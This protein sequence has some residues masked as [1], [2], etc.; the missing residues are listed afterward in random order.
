[1]SRRKQTTLKLLRRARTRQSN[2]SLARVSQVSVRRLLRECVAEALEPRRLLTGAPYWLTGAPPLWQEQGPTWETDAQT[3]GL[4]KQHN[5]VAGAVNAIAFDPK[6]P[7]TL[8]AATV[9]GG[10]WF[11]PVASASS[12]ADP[13]IP[14]PTWVP[15]TDAWQSDSFGAIAFDP[16]DATGQTIWAGMGDFSSGGGDGSPASGLLLTTDK[17][18]TWTQLGQAAL[19]G[20]SI[21]RIVPTSVVTENPDKTLTTHQVLVLA[22]T[23]GLFFSSDR[24]QTFFNESG[25]T[26]KDG[27]DNDGDGKIDNPEEDTGLPA[28]A[29]TDVVRDSYGEL[30][31]AIPGQGIF[32]NADGLGRTWKPA[33][34]GL[35]TLG[36]AGNRIELAVSPV[37]GNS[38]SGF[39]VMYAVITGPNPPAFG[40]TNL[41]VFRSPDFGGHWTLMGPTPDTHPAGQGNLHVAIVADPTNPYVVWVSGDGGD[42]QTVRGDASN[43]DNP[44]TSV[45]AGS[46]NN[47]GPHPDSRDM[48]FDKAGNL[49][50]ADDG[51]IYR[52]LKPND[53]DNRRWEPVVGNMN[54]HEVYSVAHVSR[55][56]GGG[57][58]Y[59][60]GTQD[61]GTP[62]EPADPTYGLFGGSYKDVT[63][64]DGSIVAVD[65][66]SDPNKTF[67]FTSNNNLIGFQMQTFEL[68]VDHGQNVAPVPVALN[69]NNSGMALNSANFDPTIPS[70]T[71]YVLNAVNAKQMLFGTGYLYESFDQGQNLTLLN[72]P[73]QN[74]RPNPMT[75]V[76]QVTALAY[77]GTSGGVA[78]ASVIY[79]AVGGKIPTLY[80]RTSGGG[81][82]LRVPYPSAAAG[83][84]AVGGARDIVLDPTEY[85]TAWIADANGHIYQTS[86]A[87]QT[88]SDVTGDLYKLSTDLR[89][90]EVFKSGATIV[91]MVGG[92]GGVFKCLNPG[93]I[94]H[95]R[96]CGDGLPGVMVKD[97]HYDPIKDILY[98]GTWGRGIWAMQAGYIAGV[99][100]DLKPYLLQEKDILTVTGADPDGLFNSESFEVYTD[101]ANPRLLT[102][103]Y[104]PQL[105]AQTY[106]LQA[107]CI[108]G[109][110]IKTLSG[111]DNVKID[112]VPAY[113]PVTVDTGAADAF[114]SVAA[115]QTIFGTYLDTRGVHANLTITG[116][117]GAAGHKTELA[118]GAAAFAGANLMQVSTGAGTGSITPA[119]FGSILYDAGAAISSVRLETQLATATPQV[120]I[121]ATGV[122][123]TIE[124]KTQAPAGTRINAEFDIGSNNS[125]A[126]ITAALSLY[127]DFNPDAFVIFLD[128]TDMAKRPII[129]DE[130]ADPDAGVPL[131]RFTGLAPAT[132]EI[133][134]QITSIAA[135]TGIDPEAIYFKG[136][137]K[138]SISVST[139]PLVTL[140]NFFD[141]S[142]GVVARDAPNFQM[143][144]NQGVGDVSL[145]NLSA[146]NL[147]KN[148]IKSLSLDEGAAGA[149]VT[150]NMISGDV[151]L[152][153]LAGTTD[154]TSF[155]S[156]I[157]KG[158]LTLRGGADN[159]VES[160]T[161]SNLTL[162]GATQRPVVL[163]NTIVNT[164]QISGAGA[165][166][167]DIEK[168]RIGNIDVKV[169]AGGTIKGNNVGGVPQPPV[170]ARAPQLDPPHPAPAI[171][172]Q[173]IATSLSDGFVGPLPVPSSQASNFVGPLQQPALLAT[174]WHSDLPT[175]LGA[176]PTSEFNGQT[177]GL[178]VQHNPVAGAVNA[179]APDPGNADIL[180]VA[181]VNGGIWKTTNAR[182]VT[183]DVLEPD[184]T[185]LTERYQSLSFGAIAF[186]PTDKTNQTL[187]AGFDRTSSGSFDGGGEPGLLRTSDGGKTWVPM[188]TAPFGAA[189]GLSGTGVRNIVP[190]TIIDPTSKK[191]VILA[192]TNAGVF[193]SVDGGTIFTRVSGASGPAASGLTAGNYTS[194]VADPANP[195]RFYA[196]MTSEDANA[197]NKLDPGED[198][199]GDKKLE[200][201]HLYRSDDG[202]ATWKDVSSNVPVPGVL[203]SAD[204]IRLAVHFNAATGSNAVW[205]A[206][207][208]LNT[209]AKPPLDQLA[210]VFRSMSQ[211]SSWSPISK[212]AQINPEGQA[213]N[214]SIAADPVNPN[215]V[216][217][218]G[219]EQKGDGI[220]HVA[221]IWRGDASTDNFSS[222]VLDGANGTAPH[223]DSR[224]MAFDADGNLINSNDGGVYRLINPSQSSR[225][226]V[227]AIGNL[228]VHEL[229]SAAYVHGFPKSGLGFVAGAQDTGVPEQ[230]LLHGQGDTY[231]ARDV[232]ES[233]GALV[234]VDQNSTPGHSY[235]YSSND[236]LARFT[237]QEFDSDGNLVQQNTPPLNVNGTGGVNLSSTFDP[238]VRFITPWVMNSVDGKRL[239]FGTNYLYE[240]LDRGASLTMLNGPLL[241]NLPDPA[242]GYGPISALAYGG[243]SGGID[244]PDVLYAASG[245]L[246]F[247]KNAD[248]TPVNPLKLLVRDDGTGAPALDTYPPGT[249]AA[250]VQGARAI[251][252][253]P[254]EWKTVYLL[255][256]NGHIYRSTDAGNTAAGWTDITGDLGNLS[257]DLRCLEL[258]KT[259]GHTV[260]LAGGLGGVFRTVDPGAASHWRQYGTF[261][262]EAIATDIHYDATDD[263]FYAAT[264]GRGIQIIHKPVNEPN[265][266]SVL[267]TLIANNTLTL[268]G[269][270][271]SQ[272]EADHIRIYRDPNNSRVLIATLHD[273]TGDS[274]YTVDASCLDKIV[275]QGG[276]G[277]DIIDVDV[278]DPNIKVIVDTGVG[279]DT[280]HVGSAG[281][282]SGIQAPLTITG[283][284]NVAGHQTKIFVDG[285]ADPTGAPLVQ[286]NL[287][288]T[289]GSI[290]GLAPGT[291][292]YDEG[293]EV[294]DVTISTGPNGILPQ[295]DVI[296]AAIPLTIIDA[297]KDGDRAGDA[298]HLGSGGKVDTITAPIFVR[299][300][301]NSS[302]NVTLDDGG[303]NIERT[304]TMEP[305]TDPA[306]SERFVS[307]TGVTTSSVIVQ[308]TVASV[309]ASTGY[310]VVAIVYNGMGSPGGLRS[311]SVSG[312]PT[313]SVENMVL[314]A[315]LTVTDAR[316][317][318]AV[319]NTAGDMLL[320]GSSGGHIQANHL[321]SLTLTGG[322]VNPTVIGNMIYGTLSINADGATGVDI[323]HNVIG[324]YDNAAHASG[325]FLHNTVGGVPQPLRAAALRAG[326]N[327]LLGPPIALNL[328]SPFDGLISDNDI[329]DATIGINYL[330][331][332]ALIGNRVFNNTTGVVMPI[333]DTTGG[334]G[335]F[336]GSGSNDIHDNTVGVNLTGRMQKQHIYSNQ[337][338]VMGSGILG[339]DTLDNANLIES[340]AVGAD[341]TGVIQD[342]RFAKNVVGVLGHDDLI[343]VHNLI[344]RGTTAGIETNG[345]NDLRVVQNT[346]YNT[347]GNAVQVDGGSQRTELLNNIFQADGGYDLYVNDDSQTGFFSDFN[348][349]YS[350]GPGKIV[351]WFKDYTDILALQQELD[352]I[353]LHSIGTSP[354]SP[355]FAAPQF[356]NLAA[357]DLRTAPLTNG[358]HPTSPTI[359]AGSPVVDVPPPPGFKNLLSN[360][361][362]E[363]GTGSWT[364]N[365]GGATQGAAPAPFAFGG[366]QYFAP[367]A[368]ATGFAEQTV[369]L[370]AAG[371]SAA[372]LDSQTLV[373]AF[374]ARLRSGNEFPP[375]DGRLLLTFLDASGNAVTA[376]TII[377]SADVS[378]RWELAG[379]RVSVPAGAR[380]VKFRFE[381]LR[382]SGTTNDA[383]LDG[384]FLD[385][386]PS[387]RE[388]DQGA[389][390]ATTSGDI[391]LT[392]AHIQLLSPILYVDWDVGIP[393]LIQ[394]QTFGNTTNAPVK[395]DLYQD[396]ANGPQLLLTIAA[397]TPD[398]GSFAW[399][400]QSSG[401]APGTR[402]LR[403]QVSLAGS[404]TVFD[405]SAEAFSL[406]G[407][408]HVYYINDAST[409]G[410]MLTT[411]PGDYRNNGT[412]PA[413]PK[414]SLLALLREYNLG[415]TDTIYIDT[416]TYTLPE[417][418]VLSGNPLA[419]GDQGVTI[420]G[421]TD[422]AHVASLSVPDGLPVF[423]VFAGTFVTL[424][425]LTLQGGSYGVLVHDGSN[426]FTGSYLTSNQAALD[427]IRVESDSTDVA[428]DHVNVTG[429]GRDGIFVG[430]T[431]AVISASVVQG[432]AV[433]GI[434]LPNATNAVVTGNESSANKYGIVISN[435]TPGTTAT[436]GNTDL[437]KGLGNRVHDNSTYGI[438]AGYYVLVAGNTVFGTGGGQ[439]PPSGTDYGTGIVLSATATATEN[440]VWSNGIGIYSPQGAV[441]NNRAFNNSAVG[442][443]LVNA[444]AEGNVVYSNGT[445]ILLATSAKGTDLR[446]NLVY[447]NAGRG[448][449]I[450]GGSGAAVE[451]N[452]VYQ[453]AGDAIRIEGVS[454]DA[455]SGVRLRNNILWTAGP[456][457]GLPAG[458]PPSGF[459]L[460]VAPDS[461]G[462]FHSD[463]NL[464]YITGTGKIGYWENAA[465]ATLSDWRSTISQ[466]THSLS[467]PPAFVNAAG[468][469]NLLGFTGGADHGADDDFHEQSTAGSFHGG[470]LAPLVLNAPSLPVF[471]TP[472]VT[473]DAALS[474]A[475]DRGDPALAVINET[476]PNGGIANLGAYGNTV[477]ASK[478]PAAYVIVLHPD[479]GETAIPGQTFE[480]DWNSQNT[481]GTSKIDLLEGT[482]A[483]S[484][485]VVLS[486]AAAAPNTGTFS[487]TVPANLPAKGDYFI[488]VTRGDNP[489][490]TDTSDA[491]FSIAA[492]SHFFYVNDST[493]QAGDWTSVPGND[494]ND[495][496]TPATP[497][498][499]IQALLAAYHLGTGDVVRVDAGSYT[500]TSNILLT[501]DDANVTI[502]GFSDPNDA[503]RRALLSRGNA[504]GA[505]AFDLQNADNVTLDHLAL[506]GGADVGI[507]AGGGADSNHVT[508]SN[509]DIY[510]FGVYGLQAMQGNDAWTLTGNRIHDNVGVF[511]ATGATIEG[512]NGSATNV[513]VT[514]NAF[515]NNGRIGFFLYNASGTNTITGNEAYHDG[516]G[517]SADHATISA[518]KVH[519]NTG[520]GIDVGIGSSAIGNTVSNADGTSNGQG[521]GISAGE[522]TTVKGNIVFG[523]RTGIAVGSGT[524]T[525]TNN[526]VHD[527]FATGI[528][529]NTSAASGNVIYGNPVGIEAAAGTT[530]TNNLLYNNSIKGILIHGAG[531]V[532]NNTVVQTAGDAVTIEGAGATV[533]NNILWAKA[534]YDLVL[535][536]N[537][538]QGFHS[539]YND[540]YT[541]GTGKVGF[542][543]NVARSTLTDWRNASLG[544]ADSFSADP[545]FV[546]ADAADFH[547][548]ST[549]GSFH[550]GS[551]APVLDA[552]TGLPA[553]GVANETKDAA[554]SPAIDAG[555]PASSA[556]LE[557]APNG[558]YVNLGAFGN[559]AQAS[560]SP[561]NYL[562]VTRPNGGEALAAGQTVAILWTNNTPGVGTVA[563]DL[564]HKD[565]NGA[566]TLQA[567]IASAALN[568]G[569]FDWTIPADV[570]SASD[571]VIRITRA[572]A[573]P[574]SD[575]SDATFSIGAAT[576][577]YYVND[578]T[579]QTGDWTT[580]AGSDQ[581]DGL[582][583]AKPKASIA[584]I[585]AAYT[586][587]AGDEIRVDEGMYTLDGNITLTTASSGVTIRGFS[588]PTFPDRSAVLNRGSAAPSATVFVLADA[589][590]VTLDHLSITGGDYGIRADYNANSIGVTVSNCDIHD[591]VNYGVYVGLADDGWLV[592]HNRV[593]DNNRNIFA[594]QAKISITNNIAFNGGQG[595][596]V[597]SGHD[598]TISGNETY[599]NRAAGIYAD[600]ATISNNL[601]H[602]NGSSGISVGDSALAVGNTVYGHTA[603]ISSPGITL[604]GGE[605]RGNTV[606]GNSL[607]II[608]SAATVDGN[609]VFNNT[610]DG[611]SAGGGSI[612][613]ANTVY[614]NMNGIEGDGGYNGPVY[615]GNLVY[616]NSAHG[617]WLHGGISAQIAGNTIYQPAGDCLVIDAGSYNS[618]DIHISDNIFSAQAG[619]DIRV[620]DHAIPGMTS[621]YNDLYVSG[622]AKVAQWG[623]QDFATR[624]EWT[625]EF[626]FDAHS[627]SADP[628]FINPAGADGQLGYVTA[629]GDK[630]ADDNFHLAGGSP[631]IDAADPAN[632]PL[633]EPN[634]NGGR[635]NLG[636]F[637][638][639]TQADP[640][641]VNS[642]QLLSP[643]GLEKVQIGQTYPITWRS[644]GLT[645]NRTVGL[646]DTGGDDV[647][648]AS[649]TWAADAY[650]TTA[651][652]KSTFAGAIDLSGVANPAPLGVYQTSSSAAHGV[653][654]SM[655]YQ[656]PVPDGT[657]TLRLHWADL[658]DSNPGQRQ[659]DIKLQGEVV[660]SAF[661]VAA[662]GGGYSGGTYRA[663]S[664]AFPVTA[665]GGSG[666]LL[667]LVN[668]TDDPAFLSGIEITAANSAGSANP[669]ASLDVSTDNGQTWKRIASNQPMDAAGRG[670][671]NWTPTD[672]TDGNTALVRVVVDGANGMSDVSDHAFLI[673]PAGHDFYVNDASTTGDVFTTAIGDNGA[674]G[675]TP[676]HPMATL[677]GLLA[678]YHLSAGDV[679]HVDAGTWKL[680]RDI[681]IDPRE[682]GV[683]I[684]GPG[685]KAGAPP[686]S[687]A[688]FDRQ[689]PNAIIFDVEVAQNV[690]FDHLSLTNADI[691][692]NSPSGP[693]AVGLGGGVTISNCDIYSMQDDGIFRYSTYGDDNWT[694]TGNTV[695]DLGGTYGHSGYGIQLNGNFRNSVVSDNVVFNINHGIYVN[696]N[697]AD[698][699]IAGNEVYGT[700]LGIYSNVAALSGN[701]VHDSTTGLRI[702]STTIASGN[703]IYS[704]TDGV[705]VGDTGGSVR[706]EDNR[707]FNNSHSGIT[708]AAN[709][710]IRA[711][712]VYSNGIG[713]LTPPTNY[714]Y[715]GILDSNLVYANA[716][717]GIQL[718]YT[719]GARAVNNTVYQLIG[720]AIDVSNSTNVSLSNNILWVEAGADLNVSVDGQSGFTSDYNLL[721]HGAG[722]QALTGIWG[723]ANDLAL[724]DWQAASGQD[725]HSLSSDPKFVDADG[726][727]NVLGYRPAGN[728]QPGYD[729][730]VD[731]NFYLLEGSPA[732]DHANSWLAGA[733]D[734]EGFPHVDEPGTT[735]AGSPDYAPTID[736]ASQ[737]ALT[738]DRMYHTNSSYG[739]YTL[740]FSFP[741]YDGTYTS[742]VVTGEGYLQFAGPDTGSDIDN[743][744]AEF[745]RNRRIA[746]LWDNIDP[747]GVDDGVFIDASVVNQVKFSWKGVN[748][749]DK[750][751]VS[752]SAVLFSDGRIRFDYGL[753]N[754]GLSP[755]VGLSMGDGIHHV[756][757]NGYD[758][759]ATL[760]NAKSVEFAL[761]PGFVDIG[762]YEFRGDSHDATPPT[763]T[764]VSASARQVTINFSEAPNPIDAGSPAAYELRGAGPDN[765]F[766]TADDVIFAVAPR[767]TADSTQVTLDLAADLV[768][769]QHYRLTIFSTPAGGIHDLSGVALDGDVN[770][771]PGGNYVTTFVPAPPLPPGVIPSADAVFSY[772]NNVLSV[773]AGTLTFTLDLPAA[774]LSVIADGANAKLVFDTTE[775]LAGLT[776]KNGAH[777]MIDSVGAGRSAANHR[778]LV[779]S[780]S[781]GL[782]I[783]GTSLLNV[784]DN[785]LLVKNGD[786]SAVAALLAAGRGV[787]PGGLADG[788]WAGA[789]GITSSAAALQDGGDGQET[790]GLG[791]GL[792]GQMQFAPA[793]FDGI[794][795]DA[796][797]LLIKFTYTGDM[798]LDGKIDNQDV[799][800]M[801]GFYD[802]GASLDNPY[803]NGD[804]NGD[805]KIDNKDVTILAGFYGNGTAASGSPVL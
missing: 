687:T 198:L 444:I 700:D 797:D 90:I 21:E 192:A 189:G 720:D 224:D 107:A 248:G 780:G 626:G 425:H 505:V 801:A 287:L 163:S 732:T 798:N 725:S 330:V 800:I 415:A 554:D 63:K 160:S 485:T 597:R 475:L 254:D 664:L 275:I 183:G 73:L 53:A 746:P 336:T 138:P 467:K 272:N 353:D 553:P 580:A 729:G 55:F 455:T 439:M 519:D 556:A 689:N 64:G 643:N 397:S 22:T 778:V 727:D 489:A 343:V 3:L 690:T 535:S 561:A 239:L 669:T 660:K 398:N 204:N 211:G 297:S 202:G 590:N 668:V 257:T 782:S 479:G 719:N 345:A 701:R 611:I 636:N 379:A 294:N 260:L 435:P 710:V 125:L 656:L 579:V 543:E 366:S 453:L 649:G 675:K 756:L 702:E 351:H 628:Q 82:P 176:F 187:W 416:G 584:A 754:A 132:V 362:F 591:N 464:L 300:P 545:L 43:T 250:P 441:T 146:A 307:I 84:P 524:A 762:A 393:H 699:V 713:I 171:Q 512:A 15:L 577:V 60:A 325:K 99:K 289:M 131:I 648:S 280:V 775:H 520:T 629:S 191:Q 374:G 328:E 33:N 680:V 246:I 89:T 213:N 460:S 567:N 190:T 274:T 182:V 738:G 496:L 426:H 804:L 129:L 443:S 87:G 516:T 615:T 748:V 350:T 712:Y 322:T 739:N 333:N 335:Y 378:D 486:I 88:W 184:W 536:P 357:D 795:P 339:P 349:L 716:K 532:I 344:Y 410:D 630:G 271:D 562:H 753:G 347:A 605:A 565:G 28:G 681:L 679:V 420:T 534:G 721:Y 290:A 570:P 525:V 117:A 671:F 337:T 118:V 773:T 502:Q 281:D 395:I 286:V 751:P 560:K 249:M 600:H 743:T 186:D 16:G 665:S 208:A 735:N 737:F 234:A 504:S 587:G 503:T 175:W 141:L 373:A 299:S 168:N 787:K 341:F 601:V 295:V 144:N 241:N 424:K 38:T 576:H 136:L 652:S 572:G 696:G 303:D 348:D 133:G 598:S 752:F 547:E 790:V 604:S 407:T 492:A 143:L 678:S 124:D 193:R 71:P 526:L 2:S 243:R 408:S 794:K 718:N 589:D 608:A 518:N 203:Q 430:S 594:D 100:F 169:P 30:F 170:A 427:G 197:N 194:L 283:T 452:T 174:S 457:A 583:P 631:A 392:A 137:D 149:A 27:K 81:M 51:G 356:V 653:G 585:L 617:I 471:P 179:V 550:G 151:A 57:I 157:V 127:H 522:Q 223:A 188:A 128:S 315:G 74:N 54:V 469:D 555:D 695:H 620:T 707:I 433:A 447:A 61:T 278:T 459:D 235:I 736:A 622:T 13:A 465:A 405:R 440:V 568:S 676:D 45:V 639:T 24:G 329:H 692:I 482:S 233:D 731:D 265:A 375:D 36:V 195:S 466:E 210:G 740:P 607:G 80:V 683:R 413:T 515:Y 10:I 40:N 391:D 759:S 641:P 76:G 346:F 17:G 478:S 483:Q 79:A 309:I 326:G 438:E 575:V 423:D 58:G 403:V 733:A 247:G 49:L 386:R 68:S 1:M 637:G 230:I 156:N 371:Y 342:N 527:N 267:S 786:M 284:P 481:T 757:L 621:D 86:D 463:Y 528:L 102:L 35:T 616:A 765:T 610:T 513:T 747:S 805:G 358:Q 256:A 531:Q 164:L 65:D 270:F 458:S 431:G 219:D 586:L 19:S 216:Y 544:D 501:A 764:S 538:A 476:A 301:K 421:P 540:L 263:I 252:L 651:L 477:Q 332:T 537:T 95:W 11:T 448:I 72:G 231:G 533:R 511:A 474:P 62:E 539:D 244:H 436:V 85:K 404:P 650:A 663:T 196:A 261:Y 162:T 109:I 331:P 784:S 83:D 12:Y 317:L 48:I 225:H 581:N 220:P 646:V 46:A 150:N 277:N 419:G 126:T 142:G 411:A 372:Q 677:T 484:A 56:L 112:D 662:A 744:N 788:T 153:T 276:G 647:P 595:I 207:E 495:G 722:A 396:G 70:N 470:A 551:L 384:A 66:R 609:R 77:G 382:R 180:Y 530:L 454:G 67:I 619:Y 514:G 255:D 139:Q 546:N 4:D 377:T 360:P 777:A 221:N 803:F 130:N 783:D 618:H 771:A 201:A 693:S 758:A 25:S 320:S 50:Q 791:F 686:S 268:S 285:S 119:G 104:T 406:P 691:G 541:S 613:S 506:T 659:F 92:A 688:L 705:V 387:T 41:G 37:D 638:N 507:F 363:T 450:T 340:N 472:T 29:V 302:T 682:D 312:Q 140:Q 726:V 428:I 23:S 508:V 291:I 563:I 488:R 635:D 673:A 245:G 145:H 480:I 251:K 288:K 473:N 134:P 380:S 69:V 770:G 624:N 612:V 178:D 304:I 97:L 262:R 206:I 772:A 282:L 724:A 412:S 314:D 338:G 229:Y 670:S 642:L 552:A 632:V 434:D 166:D 319:G 602:D 625:W 706:L 627:L 499:T 298:I 529:L 7:D 557:P 173:P 103:S 658:A 390:G 172:Q 603:F 9:G 279:N 123:T 697:Y 445:G 521:T 399:T 308:E 364:V 121:L 776:L 711:N 155:K 52:L 633:A 212:L 5:P 456:A 422:P 31:A 750:S 493:V 96:Q 766:G 185:P 645:Q 167:V 549:Q 402:G 774:D 94:S 352:R 238:T 446:N 214:L 383:F 717:A 451:N 789:H 26:S 253:D 209:T 769:T 293:A 745:L 113:I 655:A 497:K 106:T 490:A 741:F 228:N 779:I 334:L 548:Q 491:A 310:S 368:V 292:S 698:A 437:T 240:S 376:P 226:W 654:N 487:W 388:P 468:V 316:D 517:I 571:Y 614:S 644:S 110:V 296:N 115:N 78:N 684:E 313:V 8:F 365:V 158:D 768:I 566:L 401:L 236:K 215:W 409:A 370:V 75:S 742:V 714:P 666:I 152:G 324:A 634:P 672:P 394:W 114:V 311:I 42:N 588:D 148:E 461:E 222:L 796:T 14:A 593:H 694:I 723:G 606:Y 355:T 704:N 91:L 542:W 734:I 578:S 400:P 323:E 32:V 573:S 237:Q 305:Y 574:A 429:A 417:S 592:T 755:T 582:T 498:R 657:Y 749:A 6:E 93:P 793:T 116:T 217:V 802:A 708:A 122:P 418:V 361:S 799:V 385:V 462:G 685:A 494:A 47:T 218:G 232:L 510:G 559:T 165:A 161:M 730:G 306:T 509:C 269:D 596:E 20:I 760:T 763:V 98:A 227:A 34:T 266:P 205:A 640:G 18:K 781:P 154:K 674:S 264:F 569:R 500:L 242:L 105:F 369:D 623:S 761:A 389:Y 449:W 564:L 715:T 599:G 39:G 181:S 709:I 108:D 258:V 159:R 120:H 135:I 321:Q 44:W 381:A 661:D 259:G 111:K 432:N 414:P 767:H 367:G 785:D 327:A 59:V 318:Y 359:D 523:T 147:D 273:D 442:I 101:P 354:V 558:A 177:A 667:E 199:D 792:Y 200:L 728:G 703:L